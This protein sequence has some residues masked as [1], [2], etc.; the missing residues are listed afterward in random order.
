[1]SDVKR[2]AQCGM[3]R[4]ATEFRL[5]TYSRQKGTQ[6]RYRI[7]KS[8][9]NLNTKYKRYKKALADPN[10]QP[11]VAVRATEFVNKMDKLYSML[12]AKGYHVAVE[13]QQSSEHS[14]TEDI[15]KL[16]A[17]Y[18]QQTVEIQP[19]IPADVPSDLLS[20]LNADA[21]EWA[22]AGFA[23]E[24]L[25]ETIYESLKAKYRP[26]IGF[27][28]NRGLPIFDDTYKDTLNAI[29]RKFDDY[30]DA[31]SCDNNDEGS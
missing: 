25:Q 13:P 8:C 20:W 30:E 10:T 4:E 3:L 23:P 19:S 24:Y 28:Q 15:D 1:M 27:D 6:G 22:D 29:L 18:T 9:E 2:C 21:Q 31:Y 11:V 5:Y 17:F 7:C 26:Q 12:D 14:E 16:L